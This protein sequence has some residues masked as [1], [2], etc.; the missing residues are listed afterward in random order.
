MCVC[1]CTYTYMHMCRCVSVCGSLSLS[2]ALS[3][4]LSISLYVYIYI[5]A[6]TYTHVNIYTHIHIHTDKCVCT[7]QK[8]DIPTHCCIRKGGESGGVMWDGARSSKVHV[9]KKQQRFPKPKTGTAPFT[10]TCQG[11]RGI[12]NLKQTRVLRARFTRRV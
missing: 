2:H 1:I 10:L 4:S 3:L 5:Y 8:H 11:P 6:H 9:P 12:Y 7:N